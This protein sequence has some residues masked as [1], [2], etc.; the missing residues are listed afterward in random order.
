MLIL[1]NKDILEFCKIKDI[2]GNNLELDNIINF[3]KDD[4]FSIINSNLQN[5]LIFK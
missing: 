2:T 1:S 3:Y 4:E 5:T